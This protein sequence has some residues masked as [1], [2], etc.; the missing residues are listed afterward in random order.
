MSD[1]SFDYWLDDV[2]PTVGGAEISL[3]M[4]HIRNAAIRFCEQSWAWQIDG[5]PINIVANDGT[6]D[7]V[8]TVTTTEIVKIV[9][10]DVNAYPLTVK[11]RASIRLAYQD[12]DTKK[13]SPKF[14]WQDYVE[15]LTLFPIPDTALVAGLT[16]RMALRPSRVAAGMTDSVA[17]RYFDAISDAAKASL[18]E[19]PNKPWS[20]GQ[21]AVFFRNRFENA[22][23]MAKNEVMFG[24]GRGPMRTVSHF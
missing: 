17:K 20:D 11:S 4:L 2:V 8:S 14:Y 6:Y 9:S 7:L 18:F 13:G 10:V 1:I 21:A 23:I 22:A 16:Y 12:A 19:M 3:V 15:K 5:L 24:L